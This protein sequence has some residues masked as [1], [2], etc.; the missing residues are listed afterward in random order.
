MKLLKQNTPKN[1]EIAVRKVLNGDIN[2]FNVIIRNYSSEINNIVSSMHPDRSVV[3][4]VT[5]EV[6]CLVLSKLSEYKRGT[7]FKQWLNSIAR[8]VCK[9]HRRNWYHRKEKEN[10][11]IENIILDQKNPEIVRI[12]VFRDEVKKAVKYLDKKYKSVIEYFYYDNKPIKIISEIEN[13]SEEQVRI[14]LF[15]GRKLIREKLKERKIL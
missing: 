10:K 5:Q 9:N 15:R 13:I 2:S 4:D 6:F 8:N 14:R 7:H 12:N 11:Y 1:V 3:D